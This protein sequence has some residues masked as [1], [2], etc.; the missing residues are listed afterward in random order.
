VIVRDCVGL[1]AQLPRFTAV[2]LGRGHA[3]RYNSK[4]YSLNHPKLRPIA[5]SSGSTAPTSQRSG[6][7]HRLHRQPL[8]L[9]GL[10]VVVGVV[11][12]YSLLRKISLR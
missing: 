10:Q 7:R 4:P 3:T 11:Q 6:H 1:F 12:G 5:G 2:L 9:L 8:L